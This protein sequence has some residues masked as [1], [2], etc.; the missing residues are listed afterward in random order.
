MM[1]LL[2]GGAANGKS[3]FAEA[4]CMQFPEPRFYL[5]AMQPYGEEGEARIKRHRAMREGKGFT[6]IE[7]YTD[8]ASL[9]LPAHA[10]ALLECIA[11]LT[12]NEMFDA[13][14]GMTDPVA[15]VL[16]GIEALNAQ[17]ERLIV[18]TNDVGS[19]GCDYPPETQAYIHAIGTIN[20]ALAARADTVVELVAGIP[21]PL[22][23]ELPN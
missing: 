23:G 20:A 14:G 21:I 15:R 10:T 1:I 7:R 18:I 12:A 22:K 5:A 17:C 19:D 8:Y 13:N 6:T 2:C 9:T 16:T 4:L 3:S 11:N